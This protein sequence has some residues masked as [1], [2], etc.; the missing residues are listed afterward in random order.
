MKA[1]PSRAIAASGTA[2]LRARWAAL[3]PRA[4]HLSTLAAG[5]GQ[6][7]ATA[8]AVRAQARLTRSAAR[9]PAAAAAPGGAA[10]RLPAVAG[11]VAAPDYSQNA[12]VAPG[13]SVAAAG[14]DARWDGSLVLAL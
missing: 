1:G 9:A 5:L 12:P 2:L 6:V 14:P 11:A 13:T 8:H 3:T 4:R 10:Q 7:R